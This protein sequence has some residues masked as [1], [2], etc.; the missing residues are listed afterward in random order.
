MARTAILGFRVLGW[1]GKGLK[2]YPGCSLYNYSF[3]VTMIGN[4]V[5]HLAPKPL[6]LLCPFGKEVYE[7]EEEPPEAEEHPSNGTYVPPVP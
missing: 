6:P 1:V 2:S 4:A 3:L 7:E 5:R